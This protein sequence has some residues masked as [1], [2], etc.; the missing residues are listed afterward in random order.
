[1]KRSLVTTMPEVKSS[2]PVAPL[3]TEEGMGAIELVGH[4]L[5]SP[6]VGHFH[7]NVLE[8]SLWAVCGK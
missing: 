5:P 3:N 7:M 4:Q 1:M 6:V 8:P 2:I